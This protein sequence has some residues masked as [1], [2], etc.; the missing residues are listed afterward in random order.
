MHDA[1]ST[2]ARSTPHAENS[3]CLQMIAFTELLFLYQE[4]RKIFGALIWSCIAFWY[5]TTT[6]TITSPPGYLRVVIGSPLWWPMERLHRTNPAA[7]SQRRPNSKQEFLVA[8]STNTQHTNSP[9]VRDATV[10]TVVDAN[11]LESSPNSH[12]RAPWLGIVRDWHHHRELRSMQKVHWSS[13]R[14]AKTN[15]F[16]H[17]IFNWRIRIHFFSFSPQRAEKAAVWWQQWHTKILRYK[18]THISEQS[19]GV[20]LI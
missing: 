5:R 7:W 10:E 11:G 4:L 9:A 15:P 14:Y 17:E 6:H 19:S 1:M 16:N 3:N 8:C 13:V 20:I 2:L 12:N 18:G